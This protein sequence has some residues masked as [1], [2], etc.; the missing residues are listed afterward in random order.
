[1]LVLAVCLSVAEGGEGTFVGGHWLLCSVEESMLAI[2]GTARH[3]RIPLAIFKVLY[4]IFPILPWRNAT[5]QSD[6]IMYVVSTGT[7]Q[8]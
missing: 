1:M 3:P 2:S 5:Q 7:C 6:R 8:T 4:I